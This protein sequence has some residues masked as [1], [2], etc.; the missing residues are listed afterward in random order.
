MHFW[1]SVQFK[2]FIEHFKAN[3]CVKLQWKAK[4]LTFPQQIAFL[5]TCIEQTK[6]LVLLS[7]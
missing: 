6:Y 1:P 7:K 4:G 2:L 3:K 5:S